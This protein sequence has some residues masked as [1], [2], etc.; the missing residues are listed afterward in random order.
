MKFTHLNIHLLD[1]VAMEERAPTNEF[2]F[3]V[4][5]APTNNKTVEKRFKKSLRH[6]LG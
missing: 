1:Y 2:L 3:Q 6:K 5:V 4:K